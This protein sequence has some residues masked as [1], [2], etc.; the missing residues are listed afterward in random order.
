MIRRSP[1]S[2]QELS[3]V[4]RRLSWPVNTDKSFRSALRLLG[5]RQRLSLLWLMAE[6]VA[7]GVCDLLLAGAMYLLF[8]LLQ[9]ASPAHHRWWTPKTT[10]SAALVAA[11]LV[12][13]RALME[14]A[15]TRAVVR[16]MQ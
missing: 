9:G 12:V 2:S 11:A 4:P 8:L 14:L 6:R 13:L 5:S 7:V 10:L 1:A 3:D 15:S 16:H